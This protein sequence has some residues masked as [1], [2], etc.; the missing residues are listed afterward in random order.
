MAS[1]ARLISFL[2]FLLLV[3]SVHTA[4]HGQVAVPAL[5]PGSPQV[6]IPGTTTPDATFAP[7]NPG[8]M[9]FGAPSRFGL[10]Q[11][12]S[13]VKQENVLGGETT[14]DVDGYYSGLRWVTEALTVGGEI[15]N[16]EDQDPNG[17]YTADILNGA[18][19][20]PVGKSIAFGAGLDTATIDY[21]GTE[22]KI[23]GTILGL[24]LNFDERLYIGLAMGREYLNRDTGANDFNSD[25]AVQKLGVGFRLGKAGSAPRSRATRTRTITAS[26]STNKIPRTSCWKATGTASSPPL[27]TSTS[28]STI[29]TDPP[30][31]WNSAGLPRKALP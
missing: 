4:A 17:N 14:T 31:S 19:S 18:I 22:D 13:T 5:A 23:R 9:Q 26:S 29:W 10:G 28:R 25:R 3:L 7:E 21:G 1:H 8:A 16:L 20:F 24:A 2:L 30:P 6:A 11:I 27:N 12:R 15:V